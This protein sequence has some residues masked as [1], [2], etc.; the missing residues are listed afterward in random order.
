M[1]AISTSR[2]P[3]PAESASWEEKE[4]VKE[5]LNEASLNTEMSSPEKDVVALTES[6][7]MVPGI[8][9]GGCGGGGA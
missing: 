6:T 7:E 4:L 5:V 2:V 9:G 8:G 1:L 3:T